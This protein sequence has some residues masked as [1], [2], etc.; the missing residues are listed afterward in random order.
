MLTYA[1]AK[2]W[3]TRSCRNVLVEEVSSNLGSLCR[4]LI[5][6]SVVD[7]LLLGGLCLGLYYSAFNPYFRGSVDEASS[8]WIR[9][10]VID[11]SR[12]SDTVEVQLFIDGRF[13]E[14]RA[15]EFP[16]PGLLQGGL[17]PKDR[18]GFFFY[19]PPLE[20]GKHEARVYAVHESAH[21]ERRTLTLIG[22]PREFQIESLP[23]APFFRGW[24][25]LA[26]PE[27]VR[28]WVADS[29]D[30]TAQVEVHLYIDGRFIESRKADYPRPDLKAL[31]FFEDD[32]HGFFFLTPLLTFGE[33]EARVYAAKKIGAEVESLRQI[34][35]PIKFMVEQGR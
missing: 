3:I 6:K 26:N 30:P 17:A 5:M 9:G 20:T 28:G 13:T 10:W 23:A 25:D 1:Q 29:G 22:Q 33:H 32:K 16:Y 35:R 19:I 7:V 8:E 31:G 24:L 18:H 14:S 21:G 27:V 2:G 4:I 34:G 12:P 15:A 11:Q